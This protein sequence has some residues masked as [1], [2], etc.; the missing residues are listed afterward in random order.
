M[1]NAYN[2]LPYFDLPQLEQRLMG[3]KAVS[4]LMIET[5]L[6]GTGERIQLLPHYLKK[7]DLQRLSNQAHA[8]KG[9][10]SCISALALHKMADDLEAAGKDSNIEQASLLT[11]LIHTH[12]TTSLR[13]LLLQHLANDSTFS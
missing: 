1:D 10:A 8:I 13:E 4:R 5:F 11:S 3:D 2:H 9:A 12:Y 7:N 6:H